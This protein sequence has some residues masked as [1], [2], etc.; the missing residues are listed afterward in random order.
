[1]NRRRLTAALFTALALAVLIAAC[2]SSSSSSSSGGSGTSSG[3]SGG[4]SLKKVKAT[5]TYT[6]PKNDGGFNT[7]QE[8]GMNAMNQMP[9][10]SASGI[11]NMPY[12]QQ[13]TQIINQAIAGGSNMISDTLGLGTLLTSA[14]KQAP[15]VYCFSPADPSPQ[16]PNSIAYWP[17]D[18]NF[19]YVAGVAAGLM[20]KSNT[21]GFVAPTKIPIS[22]QAINTFAMGCQSVNP[23]CHVRAIFINN[24]YDPP[25]DA[26]ATNSLIN[27]G[28]DVI[29]TFVDDPSFCQVAAKRGVYAVGQFNDYHS[30]CP[31]SIITSTVW[32]LS[33]WFRMQT[34]NIQTGNFHGSGSNP[35]IVPVTRAPGGPHLGGWGS[36]VPASVKSKVLNVYNQ[37]VSGKN[38]I[39]G[40]IKDQTG[41]VRFKAG[42]PVPPLYMLGTWNWFVPGVTTSS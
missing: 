28:A 21:V 33:D 36:F 38:F 32:T 30:V 42:Q 24:Y 39:V 16:P 22:V 31:K 14:C 15:Q 8:V 35:I 1:M 37:I 40:P 18:W 34:H 13:S 5:W 23:K 25:A 41:K 2:G 6:G 29:R 27:A 7:S 10:V 3:S 17:A 9:G 19:G 20:T 26:Q 11:Y 12:S 4:T